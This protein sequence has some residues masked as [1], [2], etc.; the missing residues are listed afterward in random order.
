LGV[1]FVLEDG[2]LAMYDVV[3]GERLLSDVESAEQERQ[4][5]EQERQRA[6]QERQ[7]AEQE[8]QRAEQERRRAKLEL[9][10]ARDVERQLQAETAARKA[11]EQELA[12]V[13][14]AAKPTNA[15]RHRNG[16]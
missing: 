5:A 3:T 8:R 7:R 9:Q 10:R 2:D 1:R 13:R 14:E 11:L 4:R 6:E 12:R 16:K 15:G